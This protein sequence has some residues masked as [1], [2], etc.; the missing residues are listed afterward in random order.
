[1]DQQLGGDPVSDP[2][3][4]VYN[5]CDNFADVLG[6]N[7]SGIALQCACTSTSTE[8]SQVGN[9]VNFKIEGRIY[10]PDFEARF[11]RFDGPELLEGSPTEAG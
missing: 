1:M 8:V 5:R 11:G 6:S 4:R 3:Q 9:F 10:I 2:K 7:N